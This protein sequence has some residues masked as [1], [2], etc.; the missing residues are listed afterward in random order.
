MIKLA[1]FL[2]LKTSPPKYTKKDIDI[3]N[4]PHELYAICSIIR[5]SFCLSYSIRKDIN[6]YF[7]F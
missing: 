1:D 4:I 3:G 2:I 6:L 5:E 7:Y